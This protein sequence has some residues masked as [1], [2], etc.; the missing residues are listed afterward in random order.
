MRLLAFSDLHIGYEVNRQALQE[1]PAFPGDWLIVA[2]DVGETLAQL[3]WAMD[4]LGDRFEQLLWVPG[5]HELYTVPG[6]VCPLRGVARYEAMVEVCQRRGIIT[7][8]DPYPLWPGEGPATR[9]IPLFLG[10]DY[11]FCPAG[12][13]PEVARTWAAEEGIT[14]TDEVLLYSEPYPSREAWCAAR[15]KWTEERLEKLSRD[16]RWVFI[17]H[18][19]FRYDL[20]RLFRIPRYSPWCG[21]RKTEDWHTRYPASVVVSGHLHMR[22]TDWR[23]GVRFEEVSTGYPQHWHQARGL[24][25]YLREILPGPAG[26]PPGDEGP[27]WHR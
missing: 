17:N 20:V 26:G 9:L 11:S 8:E 22:A 4:L 15:L 3:E 13:S 16:E 19:P 24:A 18:Y 10:Y 6:A 5:N 14:A 1:L 21:T 12:M 7:P 25:Y 27:I 2:G 23:D